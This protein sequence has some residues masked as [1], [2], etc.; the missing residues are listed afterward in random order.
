MKIWKI[1]QTPS[2]SITGAALLISGATL[3]SRLVGILRDRVLVHHIDVGPVMDAYYAAFKIPD[4]IYNL[5]IV[6]ALTAGFIPM[7]TKLLV[8][9]DTTRPAW[10]LANN[11]L[12]IIGI[13]LIITCT[14]GILASPLLA[15][16]IAP[17]FPLE[18]KKILITFTRIMFLS[19]L[20]LGISMVLGGILQSLRHFF[21]YSIAP[22]LYNLGIIFGV[23]VL[24][25]LMG[26]TGL[27]WGVVLGAFLHTAIQLYGAYHNG[28]RW[29][30]IFDL[31]H[32]PTRQVGKLMIPRTLGL[33]A[34]QLNTIIITIL[35]SLLPAG[36][37]TIYSL[38]FNLQGV[39]VGI[40]GI[41]F[42]LAV[43][44]VLAH[45]IAQKNIPEFTKNFST[46]LRQI[47]F[48]IIPLAIIFLL[49]RAQIVRVV[50]GSGKFDWDATIAT[51]NT[52]AFFTLG[53]LGA[54]TVPLLARAFILTL[55]PSDS[56]NFFSISTISGSEAQV[57]FLAL[58]VAIFLAIASA[59]RTL[60]F[61]RII[62]LKRVC[63]SSFLLVKASRGLVCP[64][65][66][67]PSDNA[68][69][70]S[71]GKARIRRVFETYSL[72]FPTF[73]AI[74][75]CVIANSSISLLNAL[76]LSTEFISSL[77]K[78]SIMANSNLTFASS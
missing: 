32:P 30:W 44:P 41:P 8:E 34:T 74:C 2:K 39:P 42:A 25:P 68:F 48:L 36:S 43:F 13:A 51:A 73:V 21:I 58:S 26:V 19:P 56:F 62:S 27:A 6:G 67:L 35:G 52:L 33:A 16:V 4:L 47:I 63:C 3:F 14:F 28:F 65:D 60:I 12:N 57:F 10:R 49:S 17:G 1:L 75:W 45:S 76:A 22:I 7:F 5:L 29:E 11:I 64:S 78:F 31:K 77:C 37:I 71:S 46:T 23:M 38:A 69:S 20:F 9:H 72:L 70:I 40:I 18:T 53:I 61:L 59:S 55:V 15:K 24:V 54:A 66:I 50:L